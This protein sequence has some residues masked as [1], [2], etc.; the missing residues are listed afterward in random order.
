LR[1]FFRNRTSYAFGAFPSLPTSLGVLGLALT[2][3]F[4]NIA[5]CTPASVASSS[6]EATPPSPLQVKAAFI[7]NFSV[8]IEWPENSFS[9]TTD[10]I[11]VC[12]L[13]DEPMADT[14]DATLKGRS[15]KGR[16]FAVKSSKWPQDLEGCKLVFIGLASTKAPEKTM[17]DFADTRALVVADIPGAAEHGAVINFFQEGDR[18]R[19]EVN[20][21]AA[22]KGNFSI[23]SR[24][25][26]LARIVGQEGG[27]K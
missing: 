23:S 8:F 9:S 3:V 16:P 17:A 21:S 19:F 12:V 10:P 22:R 14:L 7:F 18:I 27:G 6:A 26:Q 4:S 5:F 11:T 24:M 20:L 2:L 13:G 25:L 15:A 1:F